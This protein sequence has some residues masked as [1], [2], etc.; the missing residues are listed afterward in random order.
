[1]ANRMN[2]AFGSNNP[3]RCF[4]NSPWKQPYRSVMRVWWFWDWT[5]AR[6]F[7]QIGTTWSEINP[8]NSGPRWQRLIHLLSY[9]PSSRCRNGRPLPNAP[10]FE[11]KL[12]DLILDS[13]FIFIRFLKTDLTELFFKPHQQLILPFPLLRHCSQVSSSCKRLRRCYLEIYDINNRIF[14]LGL[15]LCVFSCAFVLVFLL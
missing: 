10:Q 7:Y 6:I 12:L 3:A 15:S 2:C 8:D 11:F 14:C 13:A 5:L 9:L 1:M 4:F